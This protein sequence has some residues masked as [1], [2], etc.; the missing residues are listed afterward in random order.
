MEHWLRFGRNENRYGYL[1]EFLAQHKNI[2]EIPKGFSLASY[3]A[4]NSNLSANFD[5]DI[6]YLMHFLDSGISEGRL[7][8]VTDYCPRFIK[9]YYGMDL[10]EGLEP[11][12]V[13]EI[14]KD[15]INATLATKIYL[16][17]D[18]LILNH[19]IYSKDFVTIFDHEAYRYS[20]LETQDL[21][22]DNYAQC[23]QHFLA[24]GIN[25]GFDISYRHQ[26]DP[27][28]YV[29]EY[30]S[31]LTPTFS[32]DLLKFYIDNKEN[33]E[34]SAEL[35]KIKIMLFKHWIKEGIGEEYHPNLIVYAKNEFDLEIPKRTSQDLKFYYSKNP[36]LE[37][38]EKPSELLN[39]LISHGASENRP[40]LI[41]SN[42]TASFFS[43][44][45]E[46]SMAAGKRDAAVKIYNKILQKT[47]DFPIAKHNLADDLLRHGFDAD[48]ARHYQSLIQNQTATQWSYINLSACLER[49]G[50]NYESALAIKNSCLLYT[51]PSPRDRG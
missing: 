9:Q 8:T 50:E 10:Q 20:N 45:A 2:D 36:D 35:E 48:A 29:D 21:P 14:V 33:G 37:K 13:L 25:S 39:H 46:M 30:K 11:H 44:V 19:G 15:K 43:A 24:H 23:L 12:D 34:A 5:H 7:S 51:S 16:T 18:E 38:L 6:Q 17:P 3:I 4:K 28:F 41:F 31:D 42:E 32:S 1:E 22:A 26:F 27:D 49:L 47:P 40:G